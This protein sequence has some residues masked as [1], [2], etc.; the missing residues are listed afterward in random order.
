M[1]GER[2]M[3]QNHIVVD[4]L[5]DCDPVLESQDAGRFVRK[6]LTVTSSGWKS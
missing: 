3:A 5:S 6:I 1:L 2:V 4:R